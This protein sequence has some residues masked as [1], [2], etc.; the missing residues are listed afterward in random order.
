MQ[1]QRFR[2]LALA[3][4][5]VVMSAPAAAQHGP[6]ARVLEQRQ[7]L[8]LTADQVKRLEDI[9]TR[10]A[11]TFAREDST[12][13]ARRAEWQRSREEVMAVLT[14]AQRD[15]V[16]ELHRKHRGEWRKEGRRHRHERRTAPP[17]SSAS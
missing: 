16:L 2:T 15:K 5:L 11:E 7:E 1:R 9:R 3:A 13:R 4:G 14:P 10:Q 17:D 8:E 6:A 12:R